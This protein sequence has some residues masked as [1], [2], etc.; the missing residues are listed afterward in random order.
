MYKPWMIHSNAQPWLARP[1]PRRLTDSNSSLNN[2]HMEEYECVLGKADSHIP[3][4]QIRDLMFP[5]IKSASPPARPRAASLFVP[6]GASC[7]RDTAY[8][9]PSTKDDDRGLSQL[10]SSVFGSV[11]GRVLGGMGAEYRQSR[12]VAYLKKPGTTSDEFELI[13]ACYY[14]LNRE[15]YSE[16]AR[17]RLSSSRLTPALPRSPASF[18]TPALP[19]SLASFLTPALPHSLASFLLSLIFSS[20]A[21]Q[22][23]RPLCL[24]PS[25]KKR[26]R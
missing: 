7:V 4:E 3:A 20:T 1:H 16:E 26:P 12:I 17:C 2:T 22:H 6:A 25:Q 14:K 18:L 23:R 24:A 10:L 8:L 15:R 5:A 19:P 9:R 13:G 21:L 11:G